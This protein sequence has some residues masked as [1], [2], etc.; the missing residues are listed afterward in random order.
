MKEI[1]DKYLVYVVAKPCLAVFNVYLIDLKIKSKSKA[2]LKSNMI[3]KKRFFI[4][5]QQ[6]NDNL[7]FFLTF[8]VRMNHT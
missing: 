4:C 6:G 2:I 1:S 5:T 3:V 8:P 7:A